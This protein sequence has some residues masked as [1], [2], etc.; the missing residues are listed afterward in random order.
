MGAI[1]TAHQSPAS[2]R[3]LPLRLILLLLLLLHVTLLLI[4][5]KCCQL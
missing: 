1:S 4:E 5:R 2:R 3:L